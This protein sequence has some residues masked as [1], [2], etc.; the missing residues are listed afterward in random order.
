MA[1]NWRQIM[2]LTRNPRSSVR[3]DIEYAP[4]S[5]PAERARRESR[6]T[7]NPARNDVYSSLERGSNL[8]QLTGPAIMASSS[9][10]FSPVLQALFGMG[11][12]RGG[13]KRSW[14][15]HL[16]AEIDLF[17]AS[18]GRYDT[19]KG[20]IYGIYKA[21]MKK[22]PDLEDLELYRK[23]IPDE[24]DEMLHYIKLWIMD[25]S[26]SGAKK[27]DPNYDEKIETLKLDLE[28]FYEMPHINAYGKITPEVE[29]K[30]A[31]AKS[32]ESGFDNALAEYEA[33]QR[34]AEHMRRY[35]VDPDADTSAPL[36][37][38][39]K[40]RLLKERFAAIKKGKKGKK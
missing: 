27:Y 6:I 8:N 20:K 40:A 28:R 13:N 22:Y 25:R 5:V 12:L 29:P 16:I 3:L 35:G 9:T 37:D 17:K 30:A 4:R 2:F 18:P 19:S 24:A 10:D 31:P 11:R 32:G 14:V 15:K 23:G 26:K 7:V 36:S 34:R 1:S 33:A 21:V 39:E 38:A